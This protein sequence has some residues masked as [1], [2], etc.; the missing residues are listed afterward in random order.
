MVNTVSQHRSVAPY[1]VADSGDTIS[2][3][4]KRVNEAVFAAHG[5]DLRARG[6]VLGTMADSVT[7]YERLLRD[8]N[9]MSH[10]ECLPFRDLIG[11]EPI[12][13][14]VLC[15]IR[16]DIDIDVSAA[17]QHA[18]LE[19]Q[20]GVRSTWFV[21]HTAPYYG[22][23]DNSGFKR[24]YCMR[25]VYRRL[26]DYGH[27]VAMHTDPLLVYQTHG[28]DGAEALKTEIEWLREGGIDIVGTTAHNSVSVYGAANFAIF[29]GRPQS[30]AARPE[31]CPTEVVHNGAWSP[32]GVLDERSI[33]LS[34]EANDVFWQ[35][36]FPVRYGVTWGVNTWWWEDEKCVPRLR[37]MSQEQRGLAGHLSYE[38]MIQRIRAIPGGSYLVLVIHPVYYGA[39]IA[40]GSGPVS[41]LSM[42]A[43]EVRSANGWDVRRPFSIEARHGGM[44]TGPSEY[45]AIN[46]S[47]ERGMLDLP[48]ESAED[49]NILR[50][51][52]FGGRNI[53]G[54][55]CSIVEHFH[56]RLGTRLSA[57]IKR[58]VS[59]QKFAH[60]E[61]GLGRYYAWYTSTRKVVEADI[62][63]LGVGADELTHSL[64]E[65]WARR[66]GY[67]ISHPGGDY[68]DST[69]DGEVVVRSASPL[70][71]LH[72]GRGDST[73]WAPS[74]C[75]EPS[76]VPMNALRRLAALVTYFVNTIRRDNAEPVLLLQECGETHGLW[77]RD[78]ATEGANRDAHARVLAWFTALASDLDVKLIDPYGAFLQSER[79]H[80]PHWCSSSDWSYAGHAIA[81]EVTASALAASSLRADPGQ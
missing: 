2:E 56:R 61:I 81:A 64:P 36:S 54:A 3:V 4:L 16:H 71:E 22:F 10:I 60:A 20:Y 42:R 47:D 59:V 31:D 19:K 13:G 17:L 43:P 65:Y 79:D 68:L 21:L 12:A 26:Q 18:E 78:D 27:E 70:A 50:I 52:V 39:R 46:L 28:M 7:Q 63:V 35:E 77:W 5:P 75:E 76:M 8:L 45:Q 14:Q 51:S 41:K 58:S 55:A 44:E 25:H 29:K 40:S 34:Y 62:V 80:R 32:L 38:D 72:R 1:R 73:F 33:G 49:D 30:F 23:F 15:G 48:S 69:L 6:G 11:R 66:T 53:D 67:C 24:H 74:L 57:Q 37:R 9:E